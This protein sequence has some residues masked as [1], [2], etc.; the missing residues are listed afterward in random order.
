MDKNTELR[1]GANEMKFAEIVWEV[2][3]APSTRLAE[4]AKDRLGWA[5]TTT[6][7]VLRR[8][9]DKG[10][11]KND[12]SMVSAILSPEEYHALR[13]EQFV[14]SEYGGSLPAFVAAFSRRQKLSQVEIAELRALVEDFEREAGGRSED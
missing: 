4:L 2:A 10:I 14:E 1:M 3:P 12:R 5:K 13:T 9:C 7:T 8:L 11:F 6:Y